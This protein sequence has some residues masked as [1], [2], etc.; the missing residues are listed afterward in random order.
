MRGEQKNHSKKNT[1]SFLERL[2]TL[3]FFS[4]QQNNKC[5]RG[6]ILYWFL[7]VNTIIVY[8]RLSDN[9]TNHLTFLLIL[10]EGLVG[11]F[12]WNYFKTLSSEGRSMPVGVTTSEPTL[13]CKR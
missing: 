5:I 4:F 7:L 13:R 9:Y 10:P 11:D 1:L 2:P 12:I 6:Q 8:M 3:F